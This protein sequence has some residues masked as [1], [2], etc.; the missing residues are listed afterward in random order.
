MGQKIRSTLEYQRIL[1]VVHFHG[2]TTLRKTFATH[3]SI[4]IST[5]RDQI[6]KEDLKPDNLR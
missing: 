6:W 1:A 2:L 5:N 4:E 3:H